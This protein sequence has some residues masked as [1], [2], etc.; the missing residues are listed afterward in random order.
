MNATD[1]QP[2]YIVDGVRTPFLKVQ[3]KPG[4]FF[5]TDLAIQA[6]K[7][8]LL[9]QPFS[10][11]D[12]DEVIFGS[13]MP[14]ENECNIA[15]VIALRLGCGNRMP[16]Y[17]VQRNCG[18]GMQSIDSALKDI[19]EGR[20]DLV[21]AGG[22]EAMSQAPLKLNHY[23]VSWLAE[24]SQTR[25]IGAKLAL[26]TKLRPKYFVPIIT[27]I[28]GLTDPVVD[29]IMGKTAENVAYRFGITRQEM[30]AFAMESH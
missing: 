20:A 14:T 16:A 11:T 1:Q 4:L 6:S 19:R 22:T 12:F 24:W 10:A 25:N 8:L 29:L 28:R 2:I 9:K 30:D 23:M 17:T 7:Q 18:S 5:G 26:L 27:L 3:G 13:V 21:L 15:R